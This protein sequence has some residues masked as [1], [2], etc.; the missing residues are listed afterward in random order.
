MQCLSH[1]PAID[2][3]ERC[4]DYEVQLDF[5]FCGVP[6]C[7]SVKRCCLYGV[8]SVVSRAEHTPPM[9]ER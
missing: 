4:M 5:D 9:T 8:D 6:V 3:I 2:V 1:H 7:A